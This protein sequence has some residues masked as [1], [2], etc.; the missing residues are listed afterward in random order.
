MSGYERLSGSVEKDKR[1]IKASRER[2]VK[3]LQRQV[4]AEGRLEQLLQTYHL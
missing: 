4:D 3:M 1:D 2:H